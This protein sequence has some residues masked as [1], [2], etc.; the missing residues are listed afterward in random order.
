MK[1]IVLA[2]VL[3]MPIQAVNA[4]E[5]IINIG[6]EINLPKDSI[7]SE[8][9]LLSLNQFLIAAQADAKNKDW[10]YPPQYLETTVLLD[11]IE[12]I[13]KNEDSEGDSFYQPYLID[14]IPIEDEQYFIQVSYMGVVEEAPVVRANFEFIAHKSEGKFLFSSPLVRN[15][16]NW[17]TATIENFTFRY[18]GTLNLDK[19]NEYQ[20]LTAFYDEKLKIKP[21][22]KTY[23]LFEDGLISQQYFGLPYK[24][25]YNGEGEGMRWT[26]LL[27]D[28]DIYVM[29]TARLYQFDPHDLWHHR[30][31]QVKSRRAVNRA[32]DEGIATLYG[33]SWGWSWQELFTAFKDQIKFDENTDWLQLR[34]ERT[35]FITE[36]HRNPTD[37]MVNAL[38]VKKIEQEKGF[39]AVWELLNAKEES[40]YLTTLER[41]TGISKKNYNKEV[42]KLVKDEMSDLKSKGA[43]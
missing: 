9:L 7:D 16:R 18:R 15:I 20:R 25:D 22:K 33:G 17:K 27:E 30:L 5:S 28:Q 11:E 31:V 1:T 32:V 21:K 41:L 38:L 26:V 8:Y 3:L 24:L 43:K 6:A 14:V 13:D 36:G 40:A 39:S 10:V 23:Y 4:Q 42:W 29:S 12:G 19:V 37:F 2:M 34:E 35:A